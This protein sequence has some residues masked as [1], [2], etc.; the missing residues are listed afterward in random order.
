MWP[1]PFASTASTID[2]S[3]PD[4]HP[5]SCDRQLH[6]DEGQDVPPFW[7]H[8]IGS[9]LPKRQ[10]RARVA[11]PHPRHR[12]V[13][14]PHGGDD[15]VGDPGALRGGE[16]AVVPQPGG[17]HALARTPG[18]R[19]RHLPGG[20]RRGRGGQPVTSA[21]SP[22]R[23][24]RVCGWAGR[25]C[26]PRCAAGWCSPP[27][28]R[29]LCPPSFT[30]MLV[31]RYLA[32][33]DWRSR[34]KPNTEAYRDRRD[35]MLRARPRATFHVKHRPAAHLRTYAPPLTV[36]RTIRRDEL[37][38]CARAGHD[39]QDGCGRCAC[40]PR[41]TDSSNHDRAGSTARGET[42]NS[43]WWDVGLTLANR[44]THPGES[45]DSPWRC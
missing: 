29:P 33:H 42:A 10:R 39:R 2:R 9:P 5:V 24:R 40:T 15:G 35:A 44:A 25:W 3:S 21:R 43:P 20:R 16:Q 17:R 41:P 34:V 36:L 30:Q 11:A 4:S 12:T 28:R 31:S 8:S 18:R 13:R 23:S 45:C 26:P 19:A 22:R 14:G 37:A 32:G 6:H 38:V 27:N 7:L 1:P